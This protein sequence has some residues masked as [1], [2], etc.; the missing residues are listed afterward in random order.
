M[1][2]F[3]QAVM[4]TLEHEGVLSD[5]AIDAGGLTKY[6]ISQRAYPDLDIASLTKKGA[7]EIYK[8]DYWDPCGCDNIANQK[9]SEFVFDVAVNSGVRLSSK[10]I[11][12]SVNAVDDGFIGPDSLSRINRQN[13]DT[14]INAL[15]IRRIMHYE[16]IVSRRPDQRKFIIGWLKR[17]LSY[18][19]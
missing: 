16:N 10:M 18:A 8:R 19:S 3:D 1:A 7:I 15:V 12:R 17:A 5:D 6:G 2:N 4:R 9:I 11:Q 13:P 14:L